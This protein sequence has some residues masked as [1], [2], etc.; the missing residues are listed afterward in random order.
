MTI[1]CVAR[2][3]A[4]KQKHYVCSAQQKHERIFIINLM[5]IDSQV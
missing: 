5:A 2:F 1:P 4:E 3:H